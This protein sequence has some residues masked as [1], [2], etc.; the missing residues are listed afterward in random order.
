MKIENTGDL[1]NFA[2]LI[3]NVS[4]NQLL[5]LREGDYKIIAQALKK[6]FSDLTPQDLSALE[7]I[8]VKLLNANKVP[9]TTKKIVR[10]KK[11]HDVRKSA[12]KFSQKNDVVKGVRFQSSSN[13]KEVERDEGP[14]VE[15]SLLDERISKTS[16]GVNDQRLLEE[17][18]G[19]LNQGVL[20]NINALMSEVANDDSLDREGKIEKFENEVDQ[21]I[22]KILDESKEDF[23]E[24]LPEDIKSHL[25]GL[26]V[27]IEDV[28][29]FSGE[30]LEASKEVFREQL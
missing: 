22:F 15:F 19:R 24:D 5:N 18:L 11:L 10:W 20:Y 28:K 2:G 23:L 26:S 6:E 25:E 3:A 14:K 9:G 17:V 21:L 30:L 7:R 1:N 16:F 27:S 13:T 29:N 4:D 8:S 12:K